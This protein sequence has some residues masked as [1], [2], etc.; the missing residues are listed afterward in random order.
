MNRSTLL[1]LM[2]RGF[3][4]AL[5]AWKALLLFLGI[6]ALLALALVHP[7]ASALH[8]TFDRSPMG[9]QI[10]PGKSPA[11]AVA[12]D[13]FVRA[14]PDVFGD[15]SKWREV[16]TG[17]REVVNARTEKPPLSGF[18][19]TQGLAGALVPLGLLSAL[20]A[21]LF[22]GGFAGRFG[23]VEDRASLSAFGAD[24][25][26][27]APASLILGAASI[28]LIVAAYRFV[29]SAP[30]RLYAPESLRYEWEAIALMLLR[31]LAF[32]L[33]AAYV[34]LVVLYARASMGLSKSPSVVL[35]LARGAG[36]V[37]GR[38]VRTLALE[39]AFAV[40]GILPLAL[41]GT[42][43]AT[44]DGVDRGRLVLFIVLQQLVVLCRIATRIAHLGT[45]T[46]FL[47][48]TAEAARPRAVRV[49]V[50]PASAPAS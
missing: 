19:E 20:A 9:E 29:Y 28:V 15:L 37:A 46:A 31:L 39:I 48:R 12:W 22:S 36:F 50:A 27:F 32:L 24:L 5:T 34:R 23:S 21:A 35:A 11:L 38:P 8:Q 42:Y 3:A 49:E 6:N 18:F 10:L 4:S 45:A 14:R 40:I 30:G 47:R 26:R 16:G 43:A 17:E 25:G 33:V 7:V 44:W 13:N 1:V 41:W 2:A